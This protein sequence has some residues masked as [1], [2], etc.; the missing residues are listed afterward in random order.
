MLWKGLNDL[1]LELFV[2]DSVSSQNTKAWGQGYTWC[3]K[4][5]VCVYSTPYTELSATD[6]QCYQDPSW[7]W[8]LERAKQ[9]CS[10]KVCFNLKF[11]VTN[12]LLKSFSPQAFHWNSRRAASSSWKGQH[13]LSISFNTFFPSPPLRYGVS[14]SWDTTVLLTMSNVRWQWCKK[15]WQ[16]SSLML[17]CNK[18]FTK[19]KD[20]M[21]TVNATCVL[22]YCPQVKKIMRSNKMFRSASI[23]FVCFYT[24]A[25]QVTVWTT[26]VIEVVT[27][28]AL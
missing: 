3:I 7:C 17:H 12:I 15:G 18:P 21:I 13:L 23:H 16:L 5:W 11:E 22:Y 6:C 14:A 19:T 4:S 27:V 2:K 28:C 20:V 9:I 1:G 8:Q 24:H 25:L 10:W 26:P